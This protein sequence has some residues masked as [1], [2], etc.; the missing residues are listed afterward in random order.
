[1]SE[2]DTAPAAPAFERRGLNPLVREQ[3]EAW[4]AGF[5]AEVAEAQSRVSTVLQAEALLP[6]GY[7]VVYDTEPVRPLSAD[8][9]REWRAKGQDR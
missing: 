9:A 6:P 8:V 3:H 7:R 2:F 5:E 4:R 1:M